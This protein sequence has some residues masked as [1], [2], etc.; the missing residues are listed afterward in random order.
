MGNE[1]QLGNQHPQQKSQQGLADQAEAE[2]PRTEHEI[3]DRASS[4]ALT[5][6]FSHQ[7]WCT[8]ASTALPHLRNPPTREKDSVALQRRA[9]PL[10]GSLL[11]EFVRGE[12]AQKVAEL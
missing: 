7:E 9:L 11:A 4:F 1:P 3:H 5:H 10:Q 12:K 2:Q 8:L 6:H